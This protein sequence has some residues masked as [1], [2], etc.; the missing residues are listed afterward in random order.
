M[1][2]KKSPLLCGS[3]RGV[4]YGIIDFTPRFN[5]IG[6]GASN[7]SLANRGILWE[8]VVCMGI[9]H[10][11]DSRIVMENKALQVFVHFQ[12]L[13]SWVTEDERT[14]HGHSLDSMSL[15]A[16]VGSV[17]EH[18]TCLIRPSQATEPQ[19]WIQ[20]A[21]CEWHTA[22]LPLILALGLGHTSCRYFFILNILNHCKSQGWWW[23]I[24]CVV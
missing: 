5:S 22:T 1:Y 15:A 20:F 2:K 13:K 3:C 21:V 16:W 8:K 12:P 19:A 24:C 11:G 14:G 6:S 23:G 4:L 17:C 9:Q 7:A 18:G 10:S